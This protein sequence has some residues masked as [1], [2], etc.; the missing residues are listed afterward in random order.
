MSCFV[1]VGYDVLVQI[2]GKW[3]IEP[4]EYKTGAVDSP[5]AVAV[6][7]SA[8]EELAKQGD[9]AEKTKL[10]YEHRLVEVA[11]QHGAAIAGIYRTAN[12]GVEK[13]IANIVSNPNIRWLI[14]AALD[15]NGHRAGRALLALWYN[16]IDH[17][18]G[19][20][21]DDI[22]RGYISNLLPDVVERFRKQIRI[23]PAI[24][25]YEDVPT[26][27]EIVEITVGSKTFRIPVRG[28]VRA[29]ERYI[30]CLVVTRRHLAEIVAFLV[31]ACL[32]EPE[33]KVRIDEIEHL[34]DRIYPAHGLELYDPGA[35]T[36]TPP[37]RE[38]IYRSAC[39]E[40]EMQKH[41]HVTTLP[42]GEAL[43][44]VEPKYIL[45]TRDIFFIDFDWWCFGRFRN[46]LVAYEFLKDYIVKNGISRPTRYGDT[47]EINIVEDIIEHPWFIF[48]EDSYGRIRVVD[49]DFSY[50][51][52]SSYPLKDKEGLKKE[53][54]EDI[55][56]G[57]WH[58]PGKVAY[59][60]GAEL[61]RWGVEYKVFWR[62]I[63][64]VVAKRLVV[65]ELAKEVL[66]GDFVMELLDLLFGHIAEADGVI[67]VDQLR[68]LIDAMLR[69]GIEERCFV[70]VLWNPLLDTLALRAQPCFNLFH[71]LYRPDKKT[72]NL[73]C[74]MR[75]HDFLNAHMSNY[76]TLAALLHYVVWKLKQL[77]PEKYADLR[78]GVIRWVIT[79][80]H[81]YKKH[82]G[83]A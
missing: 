25:K 12:I 39:L 72:L 22:P 17:A 76:Y 63:V 74:F 29:E 81:I 83:L 14:L 77:E 69:L 65:P 6:L 21:R 67:V 36:A 37:P 9:P 4:G 41:I 79:S 42:A 51:E 8:N 13:I 75:S 44:A 54:I 33:N 34:Y 58:D 16:G 64:D 78:P 46:I 49:Y 59:S 73:I 24:A 3:P 47:F 45:K 62:K 5:V 32:Q 26:D 40:I 27:A 53:Y 28:R 60:Y 52:K 50:V 18:T 80:C 38:A 20:I 30:Q 61:R 1:K 43:D 55:L 31:H 11:I 66:L 15:E 82:V 23:I 56:N 2:Y 57:L 71:F 19:R 68:G 10:E 48:E 7:R 70:I 35:Y